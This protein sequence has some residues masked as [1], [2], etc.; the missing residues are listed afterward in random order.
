MT[1]HGSQLIWSIDL[2][3]C[4]CITLSLMQKVL[5]RTFSIRVTPRTFPFSLL[6]LGKMPVLTMSLDWWKGSSPVC[7][8]LRTAF[9]DRAGQLTWTVVTW[10]CLKGIPYPI[11]F[12]CTFSE[13]LAGNSVNLLVKHSPCTWVLAH[14]RTFSLVGSLSEVK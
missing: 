5:R 8:L 2:L 10:N 13:L 12:R 6:Q 4:I 11:Q 14:R 3:S 1:K 9:I 7:N